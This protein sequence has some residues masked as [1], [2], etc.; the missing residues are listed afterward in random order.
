MKHT[1]GKWMIAIQ[2]INV[3]RQDKFEVVA[4]TP[5]FGTMG[6]DD[7]TPIWQFGTH[8]E[9]K[10]NAKLI[11]QAPAMYEALKTIRDAFWTEGSEHSGQKI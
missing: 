8:E 3:H 1:K 4:D 5:Y 10:G 6:G 7:V 11:S 9:A 2:G